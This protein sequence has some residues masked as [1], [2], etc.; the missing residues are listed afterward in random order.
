MPFHFKDYSK[1]MF[2]ENP[3]EVIDKV[4]SG[5]HNSPSIAQILNIHEP[6]KET[7]LGKVRQ[8]EIELGV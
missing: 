6:R 7:K 3:L 1:K 8:P 2:F 4:N 5:M